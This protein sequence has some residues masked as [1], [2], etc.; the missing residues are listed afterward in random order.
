LKS[1]E[2]TTVSSSS[3]AESAALDTGLAIVNDAWPVLS[4][5][6]RSIIAGMARK[7]IEKAASDRS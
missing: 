1:P 4:P 3:A 6:S 7:A 2:K 5:R